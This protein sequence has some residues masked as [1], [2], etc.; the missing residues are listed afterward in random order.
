METAGQCTFDL[1]W[2]ELPAIENPVCFLQNFVESA[3]VLLDLLE[4]W[5]ENGACWRGKTGLPVESWERMEKHGDKKCI[6]I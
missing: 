1:T 5:Q 6:G 2:M 4:D 3:G